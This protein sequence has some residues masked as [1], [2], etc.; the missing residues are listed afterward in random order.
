MK[1]GTNWFHAGAGP[2]RHQRHQRCPVPLPRPGGSRNPGE[3]PPLVTGPLPKRDWREIL[4]S[5]ST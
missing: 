2:E 1:W 5:G 3:L 4:Q